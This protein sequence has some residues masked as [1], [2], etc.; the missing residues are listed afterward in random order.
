M[1]AFFFDIRK[2][3]LYCDSIT[4]EKRKAVRTVLDILFHY[5]TRWLA[6]LLSFTAEEAWFTRYPEKKEKGE[7]IH[8]QQ[9]LPVPSYWKNEQLNEKWEKIRI[10][11]QT[12]TGAMEEARRH[13]KIGSSLEAQPEIY[14]PQE[15][16]KYLENISL[17]EVA[18]CGKVIMR[19]DNFPSDKNYF[20][21]STGIQIIIH[22]T[23]GE[24]CERCWQI[25]PEVK[26][27]SYGFVC[28]RCKET[29]NEK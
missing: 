10:I 28:Q 6:P 11:R 25:L 21:D 3:S 5:L 15:W 27:Y 16:L 4:S 29:I 7:T 23:K 9:I 22:T 18:I 13:K 1:S 20:T 26:E 8:L 14:L 17:E 19:N 24:K 12:L 2:D